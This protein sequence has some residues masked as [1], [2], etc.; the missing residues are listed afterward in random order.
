MDLNDLT[1]EQ[2]E[3]FD[4]ATM[5]LKIE[6]LQKEVERTKAEQ[7]SPVAL[8]D[9]AVCWAFLASARGQI[10][11]T[12]TVMP[13]SVDMKAYVRNLHQHISVICDVLQEALDS[14]VEEEDK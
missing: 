4:L 1:P 7:W 12:L 14:I 9:M 6:Q 3:R 5:S 2:K 10:E 13:D 11:G 8:R